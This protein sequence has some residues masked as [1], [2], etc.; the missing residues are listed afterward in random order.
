MFD[1]KRRVHQ[2][3]HKI[4][5][6]F[7]R[8][9][10]HS[11]G[12]WGNN[13]WGEEYQ[14]HC[15]Y[16]HDF[17]SFHKGLKWLRPAAFIFTVILLYLLFRWIGTTAIAVFFAL[18]IAIKEIIH[19]GF[20]QRLE[21]R[22]FLPMDELKKAVDEI[23]RGNYYVQVDYP[24]TNEFGVLIHS[25]N[26]MAQK[27]Q[28]SEKVQL[29]YEENRKALIANISH[30]LKTPIASIQGYIEGILDGVVASPEKTNKY[31]KIIYHNTV[32]INK[33]IDDLFLFSKLDMEKLD[34]QYET[35]PVKGYMSDLMEEFRL[36]LEEKQIQFSYLD[37]MDPDGYVRID[38]KRI[39]Q[40]I[41]NIIGN[42]AKFGGGNELTITVELW[43]QD[44]AVYVSVKDNGPGIPQDKLA[45]V[46]ERFYRIDTE[47]T[48]DMMSTGLG[49]AIAK[50]LVEA[51]Q[52]KITLSSTEN[53]GTCFTI[54]LPI[55]KEQGEAGQ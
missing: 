55:V 20:L 42:G 23:A 7:H 13:H 31:L 10:P 11:P 49:L 14:N 33:L 53:E 48:K 15:K 5:E 25:F 28:E 37:K 22:I 41:R 16:H 47:R 12:K 2:H 9:H 24:V 46:F 27:L 38:R 3:F 35:L 36:E 45:H 52:G 34:F 8:K 39:H 54:M 32:Y 30:D 40:A 51:H 6:Q 44:D 1:K 4:H 18:F 50:E 17:D 26:E 29:S 19:L 43:R 21:K